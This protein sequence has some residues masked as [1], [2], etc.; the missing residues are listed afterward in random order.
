[1]CALT[2]LLVSVV[3]FVW[4]IGFNFNFQIIECCCIERNT[5]SSKKKML[6]SNIMNRKRVFS[7]VENSKVKQCEAHSQKCF[8][9][10]FSCLL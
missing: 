7:G 5:Q 3:L 10:I 8:I 4:L 2:V 6:L 1:M 9:F